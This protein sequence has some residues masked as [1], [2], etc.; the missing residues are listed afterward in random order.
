MSDLYV[1][2]LEISADRIRKRINR[3]INSNSVYKYDGFEFRVLYSDEEYFQ[4]SIYAY[5]TGSTQFLFNSMEESGTKAGGKF[6]VPIMIETDGGFAG[7]LCTYIFVVSRNEISLDRVYQF[8]GINENW[9][10]TSQSYRKFK[11]YLQQFER[12]TGFSELMHYIEKEK[13]IHEKTNQMIAGTKVYNEHFFSTRNPEREGIVKFKED[14]TLLS[15]KEAV[16]RGKRTT[17]LN[18]ANPVECGGGVLRGAKAQEENICRSTNLYKSLI[19]DN[20]S[21][22]YQTN[23]SMMKNNG[24]NSIF[25]GTDLVIYSPDVMVLKEDVGYRSGFLY[26]DTEKY[27]NHPFYI[28]VLT[29]AAPMISG[30]GYFLPDVDLQQIFERRI[31]N[32]LEV[33]IENDTE[34]MILGAFGCGAFHNPPEVVADAFRN[35]LLEKRYRNAFDEVIFA[36]KRTDRICPNIEA[37]EKYFSMFPDLNLQ[38]SEMN[39]RQSWKWVCECGQKHSWDTVKCNG[40]D[41]KRRHAKKVICYTKQ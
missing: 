6:N 4:L 30:S 28:D 11:E 22:F 34:V 16:M 8:M 36:V 41:C 1:A 20:A 14:L 24:Y 19:S 33:A 25:T 13:D 3:K 12:T 2:V 35:V 10:V 40:C 26:S 39:H 31:R 21:S 15:A 17:I 5:N 7:D 32:I 38:G 18:F 27:T 9:K 29:C 37:F 23:K